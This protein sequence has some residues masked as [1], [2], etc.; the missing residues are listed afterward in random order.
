MSNAQHKIQVGIS[1]CLL[2]DEVRYNGGHKHSALCT[3]DLSEYFD[4][5]SVCPEVSIGL[6]VPRK[7]IRLV[8][9]PS[10][11]DI[12]GVA[13]P[14]H[15]VTQ[16]MKEFAREKV[17]ELGD[18]SGYIFIKGSPSCGLFRVKVYNES[19]FPQQEMGRGV[20]AKVV[21]DTYPLLPVEEAGRLMD[22]VL[23]ENFITRVFAYQTFIS[24]KKAGLTAK[25]LIDFH[26]SYKYTLMAHDPQSHTSLGRMLADLG[27]QDLAELGDRYFQALMESLTK[28]ASRKSNT[29]VLSHI[30]GY[31]KNHL[32]SKE[33]E[34]LVE[35]IE[36]YRNG[37]IP[38]IVPIILL[39][40][41]FHTY[42][43]E[44][45]A[46]Q[47]YLQPYPDN[48]SLRNTI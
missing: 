37:I 26:A 40:N 1:S 5:V 8:G 28:K 31:L 12:V 17:K 43:N 33:K 6:G 39:K 13:N 34:K 10:D 20:Y 15:N 19:G 36:Q 48:L 3:R 47:S 25:K 44:Y 42:P 14:E 24:L 16:P 46:K 22:P 29:N 9:D 7:P 45:I 11:P 35:A 38:L 21:T 18:L 41:H 23:R 30:Q 2:G 32:S 27:N 4:F